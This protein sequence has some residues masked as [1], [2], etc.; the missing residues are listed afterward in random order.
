[1]LH[2]ALNMPP[3]RNLTLLSA[4]PGHLRPSPVPLR[5]DSKRLLDIG[6]GPSLSNMLG[7]LGNLLDSVKESIDDDGAAASGKKRQQSQSHA[8]GSK[9]PVH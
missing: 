3:A 6:S 1:M 7:N 4:L 8:S 9:T 2:P 5:A